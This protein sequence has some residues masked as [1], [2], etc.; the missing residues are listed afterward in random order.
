MKRAVARIWEAILDNI[1]AAITVAVFGAVS[2]LYA[3]LRSRL[4]NWAVAL[5][6]WLLSFQVVALPGVLWFIIGVAL[7]VVV[8]WVLRGIV[9]EQRAA[10]RKTPGHQADNRSTPEWVQTVGAKLDDLIVDLRPCFESGGYQTSIFE[11]F[12]STKATTQD[13]LWNQTHYHLIIL[14][15]WFNSWNNM[16]RAV[17]PQRTPEILAQQVESLNS[18]LYL[19]GL[20]LPDVS[21]RIAKFAPDDYALA[22]CRAV[23]DRY[24]RF[25]TEYEALLRRLPP[26]M[27]LNP[28]P[29]GSE[30][31][32]TRL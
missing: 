15:A 30:H 20:A 26:E 12:H 25:L 6:T 11:A 18:F 21:R 16:R 7:V 14:E 32:F 19:M 3:P 29:H 17:E 1:G 24:N 2:A 13:D 31:V 22:S 4:A 23:A 9:V 28:S 10:Q 8:Y 27:E 5:W